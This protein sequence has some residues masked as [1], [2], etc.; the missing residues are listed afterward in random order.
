MPQA[1][2]GDEARVFTIGYEGRTID[3]FIDLLEREGVQRVA[4]VR[5]NPWSRKPGFTKA[6]LEEHLEDA[7]IDYVHLGDLGVPKPMRD[8]L[9]QRE[10]ED[11]EGAY[12]SHLEEHEAA[13]EELTDLAHEA[14]TA[15]MCM[16]KHVE[17]CHRKF[18]ARR[19]DEEGWHI[20]HL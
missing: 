1:R 9:D 19:L 5:D 3:A 11:F 12:L 17:D 20:I 15:V 10:L 7:G 6:P 8:A 4:D 18:L 2:I 16:E 13:L 14:P